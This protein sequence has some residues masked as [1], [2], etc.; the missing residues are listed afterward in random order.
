M[1][2]VKEVRH[3]KNDVFARNGFP[4]PQPSSVMIVAMDLCHILPMK[5]DLTLSV[6]LQRR[7]G[8]LTGKTTS[9]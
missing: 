2:Y 1:Q 3:M 8:T 5:N 4:D 6:Q 7:T 9:S